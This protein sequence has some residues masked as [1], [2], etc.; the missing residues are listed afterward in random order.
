MTCR[1]FDD[2]CL[3]APSAHPRCQFLG[4]TTQEAHAQ[5]VWPIG[6][7]LEYHTRCS[8]DLQH[9]VDN[10]RQMLR[11]LPGLSRFRWFV[12]PPNKDFYHV[13]GP[14]NCLF[15]AWPHKYF[16]LDSRGKLLFRS[17]FHTSGP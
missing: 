9:R 6:S 15:A 2:S 13:G 14:F 11:V 4:I 5:D 3:L 10:A 1:G 8:Y 16:V 12:D 7:D 17:P